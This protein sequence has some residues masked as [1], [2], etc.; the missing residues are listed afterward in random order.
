MCWDTGALTRSVKVKGVLASGR[1]RGLQSNLRRKAVTLGLDP[2]V[3]LESVGWIG[4]KRSFAVG[5]GGGGKKPGACVEVV[6]SGAPET[7]SAL[8]SWGLGQANG[9]GMGWIGG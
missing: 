9:T 1:A 8:H 7:L 3:T 6:V 5:S 4:P 2:E